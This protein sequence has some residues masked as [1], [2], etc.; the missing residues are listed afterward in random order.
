MDVRDPDGFTPLH[1]AADAGNLPILHELVRAGS[2]HAWL[3]NTRQTPLALACMRGDPGCV[4]YLLDKCKTDPGAADD[5]GYTPFAIAAQHGHF[6]AVEMLLK[7]GVSQLGPN[8]YRDALSGVAMAGDVR[9]VRAL[10]RAEGGVHVQG[11]LTSKKMT[12]LHYTAGY[13]HPLA[14]S[15]LLEAGGD[16]KAANV[17]GE[18]PEDVIDTMRSEHVQHGAGRRRVRRM[19]AQGPAY[20]ARSWR[21]PNMPA[22]SSLLFT[23]GSA[24]DEAESA[25]HATEPMTAEAGA[26]V[27]EGATDS[28]E[29]TAEDFD[30]AFE[31]A[32]AIAAESVGAG[33]VGLTVYRRP[34]TSSGGSAA[35]R[36][37]AVVASSVR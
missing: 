24:K 36:R 2:S 6:E 21:W 10:V 26:G 11:A 35:D 37:T 12:P 13:C 7:F 23:A 9:M 16:E 14:T 25:N 8:A 22:S 4:K 28:A 3:S 30:V 32:M 31:V 1:Y 33:K 15:V 18:T 27:V 29:M 19:L 17:E 5:V 20:R 34:A